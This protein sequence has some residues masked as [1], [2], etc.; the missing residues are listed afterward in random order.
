MLWDEALQFD[1]KPRK[2]TANPGIVWFSDELENVGQRSG[3]EQDL[4]HCL[5]CMD[6]RQRPAGDGRND[7]SE[8]RDRPGGAEYEVDQRLGE[9]DRTE[10][11]GC[12]KAGHDRPHL[13][14][15]HGAPRGHG[16]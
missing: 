2:N 16:P 4:D 3:S 8:H 9:Q 6:P 15:D 13:R 5:H 11:C 1:R 10:S 7:A 12:E 14:P